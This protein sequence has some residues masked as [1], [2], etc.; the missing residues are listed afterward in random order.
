MKIKIMRNIKFISRLPVTRKLEG[1][2]QMWKW[3]NEVHWVWKPAIKKEVCGEVG[4]SSSEREG[5][6]LDEFQQG[7]FCT[8]LHKPTTRGHRV[9]WPDFKNKEKNGLSWTLDTSFCQLVCF[10]KPPYFYPQNMRQ[11]V[12]QFT[13]KFTN[14]S[15]SCFPGDERQA[16]LI[17]SSSI[18]KYY[19]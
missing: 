2:C 6:D 17:A 12:P 19:Y 13:L 8:I 9:I 15:K 1:G 10:E 3:P 7:D 4:Y 18:M 16:N 5:K 14:G 11:L